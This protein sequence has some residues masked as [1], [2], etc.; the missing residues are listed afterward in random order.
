M[1]DLK[2]VSLVRC[3]S[4]PWPGSMARGNERGYFAEIFPHYIIIGDRHITDDDFIVTGVRFVVD[5]AT[6]LF[7]DYDAFGIVVEP[8]RLIQQIANANAPDRTIATGPGCQILY[9]SGKNPIFLA[10]SVLGEISAMHNPSHNVGGPDG[11]FVKNTISISIKFKEAINLE[12]AV[13]RTVT[14]LSYLGLLIGR[15]QNLVEFNLRTQFDNAKPGLLDVYWSMRPRRESSGGKRT[16]YPGD[17]LIDGVRQPEI[18]AGVLAGWLD[19]QQPWHD[20]RL[21]FFNSFGAQE[22]YNIDRLVAAANMFDILPDSAV[23]SRVPLTS[24]LQE[25]KEKCRNIFRQLRESPERNAVLGALGRLGKSALK[26]KIRYRAQPI[27]EAV[28][29]RFP[30]LFAVLDEAVDCRNYY[31]HGGEPPFDYGIN[32][33]IVAFF[34]STLEF[35]FGASD[36]MDAGWDVKAWAGRA[37]GMSHPFGRY[38]IN[39]SS[40]FRQLKTVMEHPGR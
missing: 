19:R 24:E 38:R 30:E 14:L 17:V 39:Y 6:S 29:E 15:P 4:A 1:Q 34:T 20:A 31:V 35:V 16:M 37:T 25:A 7:Y 27:M 40:H 21:R 22:R 2:K 28:G 26:H 10:D 9:F 32:F 13:S 36:L 3:V 11:V 5:D 33:E 12:T 8:E 18:F 23:P